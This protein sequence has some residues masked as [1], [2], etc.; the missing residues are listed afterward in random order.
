[1]GV[2]G[3]QGKMA[4]VKYAANSWNVAASVTKGVYF[5]SDSGIKQNPA[6]IQDDAFGHVFLEQAEIGDME[7]IDATLSGAS[8][9]DDNCYILDACAMGSP[10]AVVISSS[11]AGQTT[12]WKHVIDLADVVDGL[13]VTLATDKV[14]FVEEVPSA[15]VYGFSEGDG[16]G[17]KVQVSYN[18][19][20]VSVN[21]TSTTNTRS[22]VGGATFPSLGNRIF[23]KQATFRMNT[24]ATSLKAADAVQYESIS[25]SFKR[26]M[27]KVHASGTP[28]V[29]EPNES[30][31]FP[32]ITVEVTYPRMTTV[33]ANSLFTGLGNGTLWKADLT[34]AGTY[35]NSADQY[36][37]KYE[38]PQLMLESHELVLSGGNQVKPKATFRAQMATTTPT[39]FTFIRPMRLTRVC[40][41]SVVAF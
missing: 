3:R 4:F 25:L 23:R 39:N 35:I 17:G 2:T 27:D 8:R 21:N 13:G 9:F 26:N 14:L 12:S 24:G 37:K 32:D 19:L 40:V 1:M 5:E 38:F 31:A 6:I 22:T 41:N 29:L 20:G 10:A 33:T 30:G 28:Y 36:T 34:Y 16:D 15:K 7:P 18:L 11:V